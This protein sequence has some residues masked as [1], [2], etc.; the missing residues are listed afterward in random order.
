[1]GKVKGKYTAKVN[2]LNLQLKH[3]KERKAEAAI[4]EHQLQKL[5]QELKDGEKTWSEVEKKF[6]EEAVK[7]NIDL[8]KVRA[9]VEEWSEENDRLKTELA[10]K[11]SGMNELQTQMGMVKMESQVQNKQLQK[12]KE[13]MDEA[14]K[15][16]SYLME[17]LR[18]GPR[19]TTLHMKKILE[20][21]HKQT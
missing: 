9:E 20:K 10:R 15:K 5:Q 8:P 2:S 16:I 11:E 7:K 21:F 17:E 4:F 14:K 1:M 19:K 3:A 12:R 6:S 13:I 18:E